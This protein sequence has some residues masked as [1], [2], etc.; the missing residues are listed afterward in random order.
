MPAYMIAQIEIHDPE[1]YQNYLKGFMPVFER[2]GGRLLV[3]SAQEPQVIEG[4]W[5]LPRAVVM[6]FPDADQ[7]RNWI[8]DPDYQKLAQHRHNS[9]R[10]NLI[11]VE[12][13]A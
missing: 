13:C 3:T 8:S 5:E 1:E 7:A 10:T 12:G 2:Y 9:A 6:E 11:L 4:N